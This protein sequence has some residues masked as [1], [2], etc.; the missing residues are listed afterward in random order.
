MEQL[1]FLDLLC[2]VDGC[3]RPPR[4]SS[5]LCKPHYMRRYFTGSPG[6]ADIRQYGRASC[7]VEGCGRPHK[8]KGF[9]EAHLRRWRHHGSTDRI[10][11]KFQFVTYEATHQ[12]VSALWGS[13]SQYRCIKCGNP[14]REWAYDGTDPGQ[15]TG[16]IRRMSGLYYYSQWPEFYMPMCI[17]C[18]RVMDAASRVQELREFRERNR[19]ENDL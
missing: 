9:C 8:G 16:P 17:R 4:G 18:H 12:R 6:S 10:V 15:L 2:S 5:Q 1:S 14:A 11:A 19:P 7:S 3:G 13:A